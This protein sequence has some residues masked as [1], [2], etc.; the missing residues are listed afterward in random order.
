M[1]LKAGRPTGWLDPCPSQGTSTTELKARTGD[2]EGKTD[3]GVF[4]LLKIDPTWR[5]REMTESRMI[6]EGPSRSEM[7]RP[8]ER[9]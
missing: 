5:V 2:G 1:R 8:G 4:R 3:S 6:L 7:G 9:C